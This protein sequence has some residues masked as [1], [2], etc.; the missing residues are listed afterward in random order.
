M[1]LAVV[2]ESFKARL[3]VQTKHGSGLEFVLQAAEQ[4]R[5][6]ETMP[7]HTFT[8]YTD[9]LAAMLYKEFAKSKSMRVVSYSEYGDLSYEVEADSIAELQKAI[10]R[11]EKITRRWLN[12]YRI[13][14]MKTR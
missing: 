3:F 2:A 1:N 8:T 7:Y 13:E 9:A 5:T 11:C 4:R 14:G 6:G 12:K 10:D